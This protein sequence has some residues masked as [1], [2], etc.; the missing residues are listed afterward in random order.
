LY[1]SYSC[2]R[3]KNVE[4]SARLQTAHILDLSFEA[5]VTSR[6]SVFCQDEF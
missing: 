5:L 1:K 2:L 4:W 6:F 3:M